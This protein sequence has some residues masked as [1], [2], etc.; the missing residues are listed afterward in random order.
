MK[1]QFNT[2][3][4]MQPLPQQHE[5][6]SVVKV[7]LNRIYIILTMV[8]WAVYVAST[9]Y[10]QITKGNGS[11]QKAVEAALYIIIVTTLCFSAMIYLFSRQ[12]AL[13]R[14]KAHKRI[15]REMLDSYFAKNQ[16]DITVL[17][18]SYD[19]EVTVIRQTLLSAALQEYPKVLVRLLID[20]KPNPSTPE[21]AAKLQQTKQLARDINQ[22]LAKPHQRFKKA[23]EQFKA[24]QQPN[25]IKNQELLKVVA[26]YHFAVKWLQNFAA[27]EPHED[28]VDDFFVNHVILDLAE[29]LAITAKAVE[30]VVEEKSQLPVERVE[31]LYCRL[32]W[33]FGAEVDYFQRKEYIS[34]SHEAN[35]A[36]NLNSYIDLMG[37]NY[38]VKKT[39]VGKVLLPVAPAQ[40]A[41]FVVPD[42]EF[43]LT[44]DADSLLL[45]EYCLRLVYLLN[46]PGNEKIAVT[47]TPYSSFRGC[48]S[49]IERIAGATTDIQHILHQGTTHYGATFWVGANAVIRKCALEDIAETE[50][51]QGFPVRRF[52]QDR[53]VIED[54]ESSVDLEKHGWELYNYPERLSYSATPPDFGSLIIQRRRWANGGLLILP[55]LFATIKER[56][57][58]GN[59]LKMME[60]FMRLN[61]MASIAWASFGLI[62]LLAYPFDDNL[63]SVYIICAAAPYFIAMAS[64]LHYC[65]YKRLDILRIYG[66]NLILLA[67]NLAGVVKSIQQYLTGEKIPFARTPKVNDRTASPTLY[68]LAPL[69]I[70]TFSAFIC[71]RSYTAGNFPNAIFAGF[72]AFTASWAALAY[73]GIKNTIV[74]FVCNFINWLFVDV[75]TK[76]AGEDRKKEEL[77]WRSVLYYGDDSEQVPLSVALGQSVTPQE[78]K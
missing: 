37:K 25:F 52:I 42:S 26:E 5:K 39:E 19:E 63:L 13:L 7:T 45:R 59:P 41:D 43:L 58:K 30:K 78:E 51:V 53:T 38:Q 28:H 66:F 4:N 47:Q 57:Q 72:N 61:Y 9:I 77:N 20:D 14:F 18:P 46:Q 73:I 70:I 10:Y 8:F 29:E 44:L 35:K 60:I 62:F 76:D 12:G 67:V 75:K 65:R 49:R 34:L 23:L 64:D 11:F 48:P 6:A 24:G 32:T 74:D 56:R 31:Q 50:I 36:M 22:L 27:S 55:K 17:V 1:R 2:E 15:P 40:K 68:L 54:T 71:W 16:S 21:A 69:V 33:I 3:K